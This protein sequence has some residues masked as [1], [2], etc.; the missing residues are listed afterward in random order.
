MI[1]TNPNA[2]SALRYHQLG[3]LTLLIIPALVPP[4][5]KIAL[6]LSS[7]LVGGGTALFSGSVYAKTYTGNEALGKAA[8]VGGISMILGFVTFAVLRR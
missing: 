1:S 5:Q 3:S 2:F 6:Q 7:A 4:A 8:P